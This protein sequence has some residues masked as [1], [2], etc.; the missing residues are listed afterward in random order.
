MPETARPS[1]RDGR[2]ARPRIVIAG[3]GIAALEA[4]LALRPLVREQAA[5]ELVAP[6]RAFVHRPSSVAGPFGLGGAGPVDLAALARSQGAVLR[7][8]AIAA[9]DAPRQVIRLGGGE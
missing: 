8:A 4:L 5:L 9:V 2:F 1:P 3:G 7:R 6:E